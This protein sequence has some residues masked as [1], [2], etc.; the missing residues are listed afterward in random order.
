MTGLV[1]ITGIA[2]VVATVSM[3]LAMLYL[4]WLSMGD[5]THTASPDDGDRPE[6]DD[7]NDDESQPEV[8][9]GTSA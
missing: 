8:T 6:L 5:G 9:D 4:V 3:V 7:G 1:P 2:A